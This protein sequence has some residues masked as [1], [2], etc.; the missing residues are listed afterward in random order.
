MIK[1]IDHVGIAV[2]NLQEVIHTYQLAF[3]LQPH[4]EEEVVEQKVKVAGFKVGDATIEFLEP[5]EPDSPLTKFLET[6]GNGIHH[7][8]FRVENLQAT[9]EILRTKGFSLI[10]EK[11][12]KGADDKKI[13]FL[14]PNSFNGILIELCEV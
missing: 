14:H 13:A 10:D 4:F 12:R 11:P 2:T 6:R 5:T 7:L 1:Q 3:G 9:L 8:T